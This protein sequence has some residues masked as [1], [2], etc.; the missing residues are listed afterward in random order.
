MDVNFSNIKSYLDN[1]EENIF[2]KAFYYS[3]LIS[4]LLIFVVVFS[5]CQKK[6]LYY[7]NVFYVENNEITLIIPIN[8]LELVLNNSKMII[9]NKTYQYQIDDINIVSDNGI[10]YKI[11]IKFNCNDFEYSDAIFEYKI[12][13]KEESILQYI[14]RIIK[15]EW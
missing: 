9:Y 3:V 7:E 1:K 12:L 11:K 10:S 2:I 6:D 15:G 13:L 14:V 8:E 4:V 5:S